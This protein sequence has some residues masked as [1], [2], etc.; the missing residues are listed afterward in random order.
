M[1]LIAPP[2]APVFKAGTAA[3][4]LARVEPGMPGEA[5]I[6][7]ERQHGPSVDST[8]LT[9]EGLP[10]DLMGGAAEIV[11]ANGELSK[12]SEIDGGASGH[13]PDHASPQ[14]EDA[15]YR[16]APDPFE[17]D[18]AVTA[19]PVQPLAPLVGAQAS[20]T[21]NAD[22]PAHL[23]SA[24]WTSDSTTKTR[25]ML[26]VG[27]LGFAGVM[28]A[29]LL[30]IGFLRW[31]TKD[32]TTASDPALGAAAPVA[33]N[34]VDGNPPAVEPF[35]TAPT[36]HALDD[37]ARDDSAV[38]GDA[39]ADEPLNASTN[40]S[41]LPT[42]A[43]STTVV[44]TT[45]AASDV[46][47]NA[48]STADS[49][50]AGGDETTQAE[51]TLE[52]PK[53][54][55][56]FGGILQYEIQPQFSDATEILT[57]A[58][59]TA[60]DLGLT[61]SVDAIEMPP[62]DLAAQS[63]V[64]VP[65]LV[66][67]ELPLSQFVS[68]WSNLSGIPTRINLDSLAAAGIDRKQS[69]SL[70]MVQSATFGSLIEQ[71][72]APLGLQAVARDNRFLELVAPSAAIEQ[73][74][75]AAISLA[76]IVAPDAER[77]LIESL[78]Q[79]FP[80]HT[81][82]WIIEDG[83]LLRPQTDSGEAF[84]PLAWFA[85]VR[86]LEGWRQAAGLPA[87]LPAYAPSILSARLVAPSDVAGLD[88]VL[89]QVQPEAR[90]LSQV[91]PHIC[92]QAGLQAWVDWPAVASIGIGPQTT[93]LVLTSQRTLRRALADYVS[94]FSMV[95]AVLDTQTLWLTT[96]QAYRHAPQLYVIPSNGESAGEWKSRLRPLTP[97][98]VGELGVG[99]VEAIAT[100]N[101]EF[102]LVRCCPMQVDFQ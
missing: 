7:V 50:L 19:P 2:S 49:N 37:P 22:G 28:L 38:L 93:G 75:P 78:P 102:I 27:F 80:E 83:K 16:L 76:G 90:P 48:D 5:R 62:V 58:P 81:A 21:W 64:T 54:L 4:K 24:D 61:T 46:S 82:D 35:D 31:Y 39:T 53:R 1:I 98:A 101:G 36:A 88:F 59:V 94:E 14:G 11:S 18:S 91:I 57:E 79:L 95:V 34:K 26:L 44:G 56:A 97:A 45:A 77:W 68:L 10:M 17:T 32:N 30:F 66:M 65:A 100:P 67:G 69:L 70:A 63:K 74:L 23:P 99:A 73:K 6:E 89:Q 96:N 71:L 13:I 15:E 52:L 84:E 25:Q 55:E 3:G 92:R 86:L 87:T 40:G 33:D 12:G 47:P 51:T 9:Q 72:G 43:D 42:P 20:P 29:V 60:E 8:A 85:T 41:E